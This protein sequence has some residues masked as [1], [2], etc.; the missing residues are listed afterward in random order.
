MK[1]II[2]FISIFF[3]STNLSVRLKSGLSSVFD[4]LETFD[5]DLKNPETKEHNEKNGMIQEEYS[6]IKDD[7]D[8]L[9]YEMADVKNRINSL[10]DINTKIVKRYDS[11][12]KQSE[13][14][15]DIV[16][17]SPNANNQNQS[18]ESFRFKQHVEN[19]IEEPIKI[20]ILKDE[21]LKV[22]I[23]NDTSKEKEIEKEKQNTLNN[24]NNS[25][26]TQKS[27]ENEEFDDKNI[28]E[29]DNSDMETSKD[30]DTVKELF[31][32]KLGD[33]I[34]IFCKQNK[35]KCIE[36]IKIGTYGNKEKDK[37][38]KSKRRNKNI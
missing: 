28:S 13:N 27:I 3:L 19:S 6:K 34:K 36:I 31:S 2:F 8:S 26:D 15:K 29:A 37:R 21:N 18:Q 7:V 1:I 14:I 17:V 35:E 4:K 33:L 10:I 20:D 11:L 24:S 23:S 25:L 9:K 16:K 5:E 22:N 32:D 12:E 30:V 38:R